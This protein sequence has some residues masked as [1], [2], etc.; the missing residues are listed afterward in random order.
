MSMSLG[1]RLVSGSA[2]VVTAGCVRACLGGGGQGLPTVRGKGCFFRL[3]TST[4]CSNVS[5]S[6][7]RAARGVEGASQGRLGPERG[8]EKGTYLTVVVRW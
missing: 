3:R 7:T 1:A 6:A 8:D 5:S 2:G 4:T